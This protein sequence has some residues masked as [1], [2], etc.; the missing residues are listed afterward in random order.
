MSADLLRPHE[1]FNDHNNG[2]HKVDK[3]K[4]LTCEEEKQNN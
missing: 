4:T 3:F 2:Q 1:Y